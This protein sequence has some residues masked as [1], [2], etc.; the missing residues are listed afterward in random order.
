M[1]QADLFGVVWAK[2]LSGP[3][4]VPPSQSNF[5]LGHSDTSCKAAAA[6]AA[7]DDD[8]NDDD[9]AAADDAI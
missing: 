8:D 1:G 3:N 7:D 5:W 2:F 4:A 6:A 9:G